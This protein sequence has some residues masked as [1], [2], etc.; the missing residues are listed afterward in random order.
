MDELKE[1][2]L[3]KPWHKLD[4]SVYVNN[5]AKIK[6]RAK[7]FNQKLVKVLPKQYAAAQETETNVLIDLKLNNKVKKMCGHEGSI[8]D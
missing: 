8:F 3:N 1:A 5:E 7:D 2:G 4:V 6:E